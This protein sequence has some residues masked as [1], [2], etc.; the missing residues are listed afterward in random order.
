[1][2]MQEDQTDPGRETQNQAEDHADEATAESV[3]QN[4]LGVRHPLLLHKEF[5]FILHLLL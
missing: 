1:M 3:W 2:S 5:Q 4:R